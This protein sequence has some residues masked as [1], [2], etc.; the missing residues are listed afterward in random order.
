[1][2]SP[3]F[4]RPNKSSRPVLFLA[5]SWGGPQRT[6]GKPRVFMSNTFLVSSILCS[7]C[8]RVFSTVVVVVFCF[9]F[10]FLRKKN[11]GLSSLWLFFCSLGK[12]KQRGYLKKKNNKP[13]HHHHHPEHP[14]TR[15][16]FLVFAVGIFLA[17]YQA[18]RLRFRRI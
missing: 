13:T 12:P 5:R 10:C 1:M 6:N 17:K 4:F 18:L 3:S 15:V 11:D 16:E 14:K 8:F 2:P 9:C 7:F